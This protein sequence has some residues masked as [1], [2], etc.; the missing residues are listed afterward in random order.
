MS[1]EEIILH[2][3]AQA[4]RKYLPQD[5]TEVNEPQLGNYWLQALLDITREIETGKPFIKKGP[6]VSPEDEKTLK[7]FIIDYRAGK[8]V[9]VKDKR[10]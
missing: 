6:A 1:K 9:F 2:E 3:L 7:Q 8:I 4:I 5:D 10:C